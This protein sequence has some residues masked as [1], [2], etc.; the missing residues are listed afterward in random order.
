MVLLCLLFSIVRVVLLCFLFPDTQSR[1]S[2][3]TR[4]EIIVFRISFHLHLEF[5]RSNK[6]WSLV[7]IPCH[8]YAPSNRKRE[9]VRVNKV[10]SCDIFVMTAYLCRY[11]LGDKE[12]GPSKEG[13]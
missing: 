10:V 11:L 1:K 3:L 2:T 6:K 13:K 8:K 5:I 9:H 4:Q 12:Q 7:R